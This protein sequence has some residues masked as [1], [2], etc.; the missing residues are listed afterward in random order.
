[1]SNDERM[2]A[3]CEGKTILHASVVDG[4]EVVLC[5]N[6]G[7]SL[8]F[9]AFDDGGYG[10]GELTFADGEFISIGAGK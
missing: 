2:I 8:L 5:L 3:H 9:S 7:S 1:M 6:D 4:R 10:V